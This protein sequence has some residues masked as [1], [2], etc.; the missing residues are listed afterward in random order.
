MRAMRETRLQY[1]LIVRRFR[2]GL[3]RRLAFD[4]AAERLGRAELLEQRHHR[5]GVGG[6]QY[7]PDEPTDLCATHGGTVRR[8]GAPPEGAR[9]GGALCVGL[10]QTQKLHSQMD[11]HTSSPVTTEARIIAGKAIIKICTC[12]AD[13]ARG[14][15]PCVA[16]SVCTYV[17]MHATYMQL[18]F[19]L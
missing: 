4:Q 10:R 9:C 17:C 1:G 3:G 13:S 6:A 8:S 18:T 2:L 7:D 16:R 12:G 5:H 19:C 11:A 15:H 14:P